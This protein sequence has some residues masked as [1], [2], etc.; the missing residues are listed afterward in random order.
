MNKLNLKGKIFFTFF[1]LFL[2]ISAVS[3]N[4]ELM[5]LAIVSLT[6]AIIFALLLTIEH[7]KIK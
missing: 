6:V 4:F 1:A 3:F 7:K 2:I 5:I